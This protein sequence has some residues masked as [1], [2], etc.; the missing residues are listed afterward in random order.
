MA[1]LLPMYLGKSVTYVPGLYRSKPGSKRGETGGA[2]DGG[3]RGGEFRGEFGGSWG[4]SGGS[5]G[6]EPELWIW[7]GDRGQLPNSGGPG[8]RPNSETYSTQTAI[9]STRIVGPCA[10]ISTA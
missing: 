4:S 2:G 3:N 6:T 10:P 1:H 5:S 8:R 7:G 9:L